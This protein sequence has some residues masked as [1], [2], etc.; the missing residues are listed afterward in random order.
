MKT[1]TS[2]LIVAVILAAL[3]Y[4]VLGAARF[5][6][7]MADA[8]EYAST[9]RY[10]EARESLAS[11]DQYLSY[12]RMV[13]QIGAAADHDVQSRRAALDYWQRNYKA[14]LPRDSDPVGGVEASNL[15]LQA[16]V[17]NAAYRA[18]QA[19]AHDRNST[20][21][22]YEEAIG[23]FQTLLKN[24]VWK[25]D[26]AYNYEFLVRA[27]DEFARGGRRK[28]ANGKPD[29]SGQLGNSG[30]PAQS[31]DTKKFEIYVPLNGNERTKSGEAGKGTGNARKG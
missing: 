21:Q 28:N 3:G 17:A 25:E 19:D 24:D 13:P 20:L 29:G 9:E 11:A 1:I 8:Q 23:G 30:A 16:I 27:R 2:L 4:V 15:E 31:G 6:R 18:G 12:G 5:E 7:N 10:D 14:V 26:A 22:A